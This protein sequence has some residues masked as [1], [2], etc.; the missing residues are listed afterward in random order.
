MKKFQTLYSRTKHG[1]IQTWRI[2]VKD[3]CY[4]TIEGIR[5]GVL[6][7]SAWTVAEPKNLGKKNETTGNEQAL[8]EAKAKHKAKLHE[9]YHEK[10]E[11]IDSPKFFEPMTAKKWKDRRKKVKFPVFSQPKLDG[12][13]CITKYDGMWSRYG[14]PILSAPHIRKQLNSWLSS[15]PDSIFDGELYAHKFKNN[16]EEIISLARQGKPTEEDIKNSEEHLE[17]WVYDYFD[18]N[19]PDASFE[20]RYY[21]LTQ[22][23]KEL[24]KHIPN[25]KIVIVNTKLCKNEDELD[26][27]YREYLDNGM[28][29]QMIRLSGSVYENDRSNN[30]LKRKEFIE[31]EFPIEDI[32]AGK[33]SHTHIAAKVVLRAKNGKLFEAALIGSHIYCEEL[34]KDKSKIVGKKNGTVIY[35]NLTKEGVPRFGKMKIIRDYE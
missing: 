15:H 17:Y 22:I 26:D 32:V 3:D 12:M 35:Q 25:L 30:L 33:G 23:I 21:K 2:E 29:G 5:D 20:E 11:D 31:E 19:N 34:L 18:P 10:I 28:E 6:T 8:K 14:K 16:F 9:G 13:R 27:I 24:K 7:T 4:R 1:Q